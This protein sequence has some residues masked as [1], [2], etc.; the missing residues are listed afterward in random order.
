MYLARKAPPSIAIDVA[1]RCPTM[2]PLAT[3]HGD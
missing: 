2:A 3:P 1:I